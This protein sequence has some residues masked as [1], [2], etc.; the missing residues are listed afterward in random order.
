QMQPIPNLDI[1]AVPVLGAE[2]VCIAQLICKILFVNEITRSPSLSISIASSENRINESEMSSD[3]SEFAVDYK[4]FVKTADGILLPAKWFKESVSTVNKFLSFIYNKILLVTKNNTIMLSDYSVTFKMQRETGAGTQLVDKQD[5]IKFKSEYTKL[6][7][8]KSDIGIYVTI[9]QP[10]ESDLS[11]YEERLSNYKNN[12]Q[13]PNV[14]SLSLHDKEI[15]KIVLT[16]RNNKGLVIVEDPPTHLLFSYAI[17]LQAQFTQLLLLQVQQSPLLSQ[18]QLSQ[19]LLQRH[20]QLIL[21]P[22]PL[23]Q[24]PFLPSPQLPP[25]YNWALGSQTFQ[26]HQPTSYNPY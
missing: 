13:I 17:Q 18:V 2:S 14:S 26:S 4:L 24:T 25:Q 11:E 3:E 1:T 16:I 9:A 20:S 22:F 10:S 19:L 8:R 12:N 6:A 21:S 7:A 5:F 23:Q 15:A